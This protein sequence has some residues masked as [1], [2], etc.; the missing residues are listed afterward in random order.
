MNCEVPLTFRLVCTG[1][2]IKVSLRSCICDG[3]VNSVKAC[4]DLLASPLYALE[5][6]KLHRGSWGWGEVGALACIPTLPHSHRFLFVPCIRL[7]IRTLGDISISHSAEALIRSSLSSSFDD[8][9]LDLGLSFVFARVR[10]K[11][12]EHYSSH[13][14]PKET[15]LKNLMDRKKSKRVNREPRWNEW[16]GSLLNSFTTDWLPQMDFHHLHW[17]IRLCWNWCWFSA[18]KK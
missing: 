1:D 8:D 11:C 9:C 16:W 2:P 18:R 7:E 6:Y 14:I 17:R 12:K 13:I 10:L 3:Q 5:M 15:Y 4:C